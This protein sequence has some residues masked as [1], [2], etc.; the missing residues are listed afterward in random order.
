MV[1]AP[2]MKKKTEMDQVAQIINTI[3]EEAMRSRDGFTPKNIE[4]YQKIG[5]EARQFREATPTRQVGAIVARKNEARPERTI[6]VGNRE[7]EASVDLA[8]DLE[9]AATTGKKFSPEKWVKG[10]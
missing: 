1:V 7:M 6:N 5:E 10:N 2:G 9:I 3:L 4:N 8:T